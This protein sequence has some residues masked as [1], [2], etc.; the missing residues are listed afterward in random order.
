[1][2]NVVYF[3]YSQHCSTCSN[4]A[5]SP[6]SFF[7]FFSPCS[8]PSTFK[9]LKSSVLTRNGQ[10]QII[11]TTQLERRSHRIGAI[12]LIPLMNHAILHLQI[13]RLLFFKASNNTYSNDT[14]SFMQLCILVIQFHQCAILSAN[15]HNM[16]YQIVG[17]NKSS[18]WLHI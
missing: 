12:N 7:F 13:I 5:K 4:D 18:W 17:N 14:P 8:Y 10:A 6:C 11:Y 9:A 15:R 1:M 16:K 2:I 3:I